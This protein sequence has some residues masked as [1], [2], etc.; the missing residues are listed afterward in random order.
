MRVAESARPFLSSFIR[1][2]TAMDAISPILLRLAVTTAKLLA[3]R[4]FRGALSIGD[5]GEDLAGSGIEHIRDVLERKKAERTFHDFGVRVASTLRS[6]LDSAGVPTES[7]RVKAVTEALLTSF[8]SSSATE[9]FLAN[10]LDPIRI[11]Q[12]LK[13]LLPSTASLNDEERLLF[14][15][16][17]D[18]AVRYIIN[19]ADELPSFSPAATAALLQQ[20]DRISRDTDKILTVVRNIE[21]VTGHSTYLR[22][23]KDYRQSLIRH[24]DVMELFGADIASECRHH[25]LSVAY[26]SL[27]VERYRNDSQSAEATGLS[28]S[29][30]DLL[31]LFPGKLSR[32]L[33][34]GE[35]G[36]GKSTLFRWIAVGAAQSM[37]SN[38]RKPEEWHSHMPFLLRLRDCTGGRLPSPEEFPQTLA[39]ELGRP[40]D[41]WAVS[42]LRQGRAIILLD[43]IDEVPSQLRDTLRN[44]VL[45]LVAAYSKNIFLISTRPLAVPP[46]WLTS[47]GFGEA[48]I[49]PMSSA[50]RSL[51]IQKWHQAVAGELANIGRPCNLD[52]L[53]EALIETLKG[54]PGIARL[55]TNPLLCAMICALHRDREKRLPEDQADL[56]E[57]LCQLLLHR[58][59]SESQL[60][61]VVS[62][63]SYRRLRYEQKRLI[64]QKL[65][66]HMVLAGLSTICRTV[67]EAKV[68]DVLR[69]FPGCTD[70]DFPVICA[71]LIER[72]G[73]L[74]EAKPG[75]LDFIHNTFK[76]FLA[77]EVFANDNDIDCL[78]N[79]AHEADWQPLIA[80]S[81][82]T[83]RPRFADALIARLFADVE[84]IGTAGTNRTNTATLRDLK[85]IRQLLIL[86]CSAMALQ[87]DISVSNRIKRLAEEIFPPLTLTDAEAL[88]SLGDVAVPHLHYRSRMNAD[89]A[90]AAIHALRL[91]G[92]RKA[93]EC[94]LTYKRIKR[95][96][97]YTELAQ[98]IHPLLIDSV[99]TLL[100][101]G[102]K[103]P[104]LIAKQ[105]ANL[106]PLASRSDIVHL[107]LRGTQIDS[108][109]P[110][111]SVSPLKTLIL[112]GTSVSDL[113]PLSHALLLE[114]LD[115]RQTKVGSIEALSK[116]SNL[117]VLDLVKTNVMSLRPL[118]GL[119]RLEE[120]RISYAL[121]GVMQSVPSIEALTKY[122]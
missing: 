106:Y 1:N 47:N 111:A 119:P 25:S 121:K 4:C 15:E 84:S 48:R 24:L 40:P 115:L 94:L 98:A 49:N 85:R 80:F 100:N 22:F 102:E 7:L 35:A 63:E 14:D 70:A 23:E 51:F 2:S 76:E 77:S 9:L 42:I 20:L 6:R 105:I 59:E 44:D 114:W 19:I 99:V 64:L 91:I 56:C 88:A 41:Q 78:A 74:R 60:S 57:S 86:R 55:A 117:R 18:E 97:V 26:V 87:L 38:E 30:N 62:A 5:I 101:T 116:L 71:C 89:K 45:A 11:A 8:D 58:R 28:V 83:R 92:T 109:G 68:S 16:S 27:H 65:A 32:L 112:R 12:S 72:S 95:E 122:E 110:L 13:L 113:T 79:H 39:K 104:D 3:K 33:I 61:E 50:D 34:R 73:M 43:G 93:T 75:Y 17:L 46:D 108:L 107:D 54:S 120:V 90:M 66:Y 81:V 37:T 10:K 53:S 67:A 96:S 69:S 103:L 52:A 118:I 21:R 36:S 31:N 82:A 29:I